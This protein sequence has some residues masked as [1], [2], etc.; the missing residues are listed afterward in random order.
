MTEK[1]RRE[2]IVKAMQAPATEIAKKLAK[3]NLVE[4]GKLIVKHNR[5]RLIQKQINRLKLWR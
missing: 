1:K 4:L 3:D 2:L 5:S